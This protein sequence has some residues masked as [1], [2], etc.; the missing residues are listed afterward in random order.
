MVV[1]WPGG[2]GGGS[3]CWEGRVGSLGGRFGLVCRAGFS[4]FSFSGLLTGSPLLSPLGSCP[5]RPV[6][7]PGPCGV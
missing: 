4:I 1:P 2:G 3:D 6:A 7:A 5:G